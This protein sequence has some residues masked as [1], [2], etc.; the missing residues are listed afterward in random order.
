M[1]YIVQR[2]KGWPV[3][4]DPKPRHAF[5]ETFEPDPDTVDPE[6]KEVTAGSIT[7]KMC[8]DGVESGYLA[9][10]KDGK[11]SSSPTSQAGGAAVPAL[12]TKKMRA[13]PEAA[14]FTS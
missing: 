2:D 3:S 14:G 5:D 8:A 1:K 12:I 11:D 9:I 13:D 10:A 6:T 4:D 7:A